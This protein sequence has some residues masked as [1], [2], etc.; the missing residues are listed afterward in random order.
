MK[1]TQKAVIRKFLLEMYLYFL[2]NKRHVHF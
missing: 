1:L 2:A